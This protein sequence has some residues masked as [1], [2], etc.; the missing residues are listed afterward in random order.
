MP[1]NNQ[2]GMVL[3]LVLVV[4][5]LLSALLSEFAFSTLVDLRLAETFRDSTRAEYLARGGIEA[6]RMLLQNDRNSFDAKT[7]TELWST[8]IQNYP[9]AA[10]DISI[11]IDDLDGKLLLNKLVDLQGN[12]SQLYR[13]R[14]VRLCSELALDNPE[15]LA[16]ALID[17]IDPD[18]EPQ[19]LGA[20]D[21]DYLRQQPA[22]EATDGPLQDLDELSLVQGFNAKTVN[23]LRP[24]VSVFGSGRLNVNTASAEVLRSWDADSSLEIDNLISSRAESPFQQLEELKDSIGL[25]AFSALNRNLDLTV[26]STYYLINSQ[27]RVN[28]GSR[29][30]TAV[31]DKSKDALLWQKVN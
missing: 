28:S 18:H 3:L 8:G 15:A 2:R 5:A 31:V 24:H 7:P 1:V 6:G 21:S 14:F 11:N 22:Y 13:E 10:G 30:L 20:E 26:T 25:E 9:V 27:G 19:P 17:W 4:I 12:P 23:L 16:D 29:R